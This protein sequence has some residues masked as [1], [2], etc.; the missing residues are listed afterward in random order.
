MT[1]IL[2]SSVML[3]HKAGMVNKA[4]DLAFK[5]EQFGPL[6]LIA[7]DLDSTSD[8]ALVAKCAAFFLEH[9]HFDKAVDLLAISKKVRKR[10]KKKRRKKLI[11]ILWYWAN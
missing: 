3:Y 4:L 1:H 5:T 2:L 11:C 9:G 7:D 8:P 10:R 6:Q